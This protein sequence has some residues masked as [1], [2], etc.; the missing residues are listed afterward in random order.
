MKENLGGIA[1]FT[2][3]IALITLMISMAVSVFH[4]N[5][6]AVLGAVLGFLLIGVAALMGIISTF[7]PSTNVTIQTNKDPIEDFFNK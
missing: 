2:F 5:D 6:L 3:L 1:C 4:I 7:L